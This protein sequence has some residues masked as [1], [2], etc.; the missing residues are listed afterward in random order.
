MNK[1]LRDNPVQAH[2]HVAIAEEM[3]DLRGLI[4]T[5]A[6]TLV[7]DERFVIEYVSQLQVFDLIV[8]RLDES[9]NLLDRMAHGASVSDVLANVRLSMV[10]T[11]LRDA[12]MQ[13]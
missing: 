8:Q 11:R 9:A 13:G 4:E 2:M 3:R 7:Q 10:Q 12:V 1:P 5:L 6:E